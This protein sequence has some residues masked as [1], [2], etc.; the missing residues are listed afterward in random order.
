MSDL[1]PVARANRREAAR[2]VSAAMHVRIAT[3]VDEGVVVVEVEVE[4]E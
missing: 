2:V 3:V 4:V 1:L